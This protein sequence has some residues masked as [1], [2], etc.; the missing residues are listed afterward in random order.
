MIVS[1]ELQFHIVQRFDRNQIEIWV[2]DY[3]GHEGFNI[4]IDE[5][6][7]LK[8]EPIPELQRLDDGKYK[9]FISM[10]RFFA[11]Q[12]F[13]QIV[14]YRTGQGIK[15]E[16]ENLLQGKLSATES[17]LSDMRDFALKLMKHFVEDGP[18]PD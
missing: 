7:F 6:G 2:F 12:L 9:P 16:N 11:E 15:T 3:K 10:P 5:N 1:L 17:H 14:D 13:K 18:K 4:T 8:S